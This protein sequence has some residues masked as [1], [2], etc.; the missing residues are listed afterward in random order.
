M[1]EEEKKNEETN[2]ENQNQENPEEEKE[3]SEEETKEN[4]PLHTPIPP[5][6]PKEQTETRY[7]LFLVYN[8]RAP[9]DRDDVF[10]LIDQLN[11]ITTPPEETRMIW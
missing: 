11:K 7:I 8:E 10:D 4:L 2:V 5:A 3:T 6:S 1:D 9:V